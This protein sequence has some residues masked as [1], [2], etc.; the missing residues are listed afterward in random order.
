MAEGMDKKSI[1]ESRKGPEHRDFVKNGEAVAMLTDMISRLNE[2]PES[3]D[4]PAVQEAVRH[5]LRIRNDLM[6]IQVHLIKH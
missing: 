1:L 5:L 6:D 2:D 4:N 3:K